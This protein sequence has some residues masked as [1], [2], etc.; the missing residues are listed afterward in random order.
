M[1][2]AIQLT[3][4]IQRLTQAVQD[5][6]GRITVSGPFHGP[7]QRRPTR[8]APSPEAEETEEERTVREQ[9]E[10]DQRRLL[11]IEANPS[12]QA[13]RKVEEFLGNLGAFFPQLNQLANMVGAT[14]RLFEMFI[15]PAPK[16]ESPADKQTPIDLTDKDIEEDEPSPRRKIWRGWDDPNEAPYVNPKMQRW[17]AK[18]QEERDA[19]LQFHG[20]EPEWRPQSPPPTAEMPTPSTPPTAGMPTPSTPPPMVEPPAK[21]PYGP[22]RDLGQIAGELEE[23]LTKLQEFEQLETSLENKLAHM[24]LDGLS[25]PDEDIEKLDK[26]RNKIE[27][28]R[29][30]SKELR[31]EEAAARESK[32][33]SLPEAQ[34]RPQAIPVAPPEPAVPPPTVEPAPKEAAKAQRTLEQI[35]G[36]LEEVL[37]KLRESEQLEMILDQRVSNIVA[38]GLYPSFHDTERLDALREKIALLKESSKSLGLEEVAAREKKVAN[39]PEAEPPEKPL[40]ESVTSKTY[41]AESSRRGGWEPLERRR[42]E[43]PQ[44]A[45]DDLSK[46]AGV[47]QDF[48]AALKVAGDQQSGGFGS[49]SSDER[50][51][52]REHS[53]P[54]LVTRPDIT[55]SH[56]DPATEQLLATAS[57]PSVLGRFISGVRNQ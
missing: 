35:T 10:Y 38:K 19:I 55:T 42:S 51:T 44:R 57:G 40:P 49:P 47:L 12:I 54:R 27:S 37:V 7:T 32:T 22:Y 1:S 21:S 48:V 20:R 41:E 8:Q 15:G 24:T 56:S 11:A 53:E 13:A 9:R 36:E 30:A 18:S 45:F 34:T 16:A 25:I 29:D 31:L 6:E 4:A 33:D 50:N 26:L 28:L 52:G 46:L 39:L 43:L 2:D 17:S 14:R 5:L 23:V 3:A